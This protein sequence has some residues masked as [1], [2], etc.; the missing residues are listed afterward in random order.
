MGKNKKE[1]SERAKELAL[2][3]AAKMTLKERKKHSKIMLGARYK[4]K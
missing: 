3:K 2:K 1:R 4:N